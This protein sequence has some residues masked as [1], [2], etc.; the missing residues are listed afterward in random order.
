M[1][2]W[3]ALKATLRSLQ[4][5]SRPAR[6]RGRKQTSPRPASPATLAPRGDGAPNSSPARERPP[7]DIRP[8]RQGERERWDLV[9]DEHAR[10]GDLDASAEAELE[11]LLRRR[12]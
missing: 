9:T 5:L 6:A 4:P 2:S 10:W 7:S 11:R 3:R 8:R 12:K 1:R